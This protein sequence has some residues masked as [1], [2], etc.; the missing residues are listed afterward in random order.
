MLRLVDEIAA[1]QLDRDAVRDRRRQLTE[2]P[3]DS[4]GSTAPTPTS[5]PRPYTVRFRSPDRSV[6]LSLSFR[7]NEQ[8]R[9]AEVIRALETILD[10]LRSGPDTEIDA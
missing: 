9:R 2:S 5:K 10:E 8:P 3:E 4:H 6:S 1:L 7:T